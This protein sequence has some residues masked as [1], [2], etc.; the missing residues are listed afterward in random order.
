MEDAGETPATP[1]RRR[2]GAA[3]RGEIYMLM[4]RKSMA[5]AV[6]DSG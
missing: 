4:L 3:A 5:P 1:K 6:D 2:A